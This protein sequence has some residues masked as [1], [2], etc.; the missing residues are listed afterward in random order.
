MLTLDRGQGQH[1]RGAEGTAGRR[2]HQV[3]GADR[4]G[5]DSQ[6]VAFRQQVSGNQE[7]GIRG[8]NQASGLTLT[9]D[10]DSEAA[11]S[12]WIPRNLQN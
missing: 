1:A 8:R 4:A 6:A 7:S 10:A 3:G 2:H 12:L 9:P 5:K 11:T